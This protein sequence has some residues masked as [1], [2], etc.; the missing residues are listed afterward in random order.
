M[1]R[2]LALTKKI[3]FSDQFLECSSRVLLQEKPLAILQRIRLLIHHLSMEPGINA[4]TLSLLK[5]L[6]ECLFDEENQIRL[7]QNPIPPGGPRHCLDWL[8]VR[9]L[10][11]VG[12]NFSDVLTQLESY[13]NEDERLV[14]ESRLDASGRRIRSIILHSEKD[15]KPRSYRISTLKK[16]ISE[17]NHHLKQS[18]Q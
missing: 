1:V 9:T 11:A 12:S 10:Q 13:L 4:E 17:L 3:C 2:Y 8:I 5:R 15:P 18:C 14:H 6:I 7:E 16:R